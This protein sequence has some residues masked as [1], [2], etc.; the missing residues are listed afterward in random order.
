MLQTHKLILK[1]FDD[2]IKLV[3][4]IRAKVIRYSDTDAELNEF[5]ST[6]NQELDEKCGMNRYILQT[7]W[8]TNEYL[9]ILRTPSCRLDNTSKRKEQIVKQFNAIVADVKRSKRWTD[10]ELVDD[11]SITKRK[12]CNECGSTWMT[13]DETGQKICCNCSTEIPVL[14]SGNTH[15]DYSRATI[16]GKFIYNRVLHFQDCIRQFQGKQN[17]KIPQH[18]YT[19]LDKK[20]SAYRL[21]IDSDNPIVKYSR[22]TKTHILTFLKDLK[23]VKHYENV[24]VILTTLTSIRTND[25]GNLEQQLIEDFKEL[26]TLYDSL[27]AKDKPEEL[28]RK[29]FL[30]VQ[31]LLFQLL[32]R[33]KYAC[34]LSDFST[35]KTT[36]RKLFHDKVCCNLFQQLGWNFTPTF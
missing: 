9:S 36:D 26:V 7:S 31:Y 17:C 12:C 6:C 15:L 4:Q 24:N 3:Q 5:I 20:F 8:L 21:L 33:H 1:R 34:K 16:V 10:I 28:D 14:E 2:E 19:E 23:L 22:I 32:R 29:N 11:G 13:T 30:N 18:V 25:I 27:H 35:L